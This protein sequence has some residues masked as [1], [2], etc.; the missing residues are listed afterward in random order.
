MR[1]DDE[2]IPVAR[3]IFD[4]TCTPVS[5]GSLAHPPPH[6]RFDKQV[7]EDLAGCSCN[8]RKAVPM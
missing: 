2:G 6:T 1:A 4:D 5:S 3:M 8:V 7:S